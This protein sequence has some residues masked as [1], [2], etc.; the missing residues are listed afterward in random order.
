MFTKT[1]LHTNHTNPSLFQKEQGSSFIQPKLNV[2]KSGDK[3]EV[4]ADKAADQIVAKSNEHTNSFLA[5]S[6]TI[7]KQE[8]EQEIQQKPV[9]DP[10]TP[11]VQL[12]IDNFLQ[13]Q[14]EEE[15]QQ[16][17]EE[18][19]VQTQKDENL[20]ESKDTLQTKKTEVTPIQKI[21][22]E[23]EVQ[24]K[25]DEEIQEK[26][27]EGIVQKQSSSAGDDGSNIESQLSDS[28]GGGSPLDSDTKGEMESG[29]GADF[30]GVRVHND[31]NAVQMNQ[32]LG[33]QAFTN[34]NDIYFN[35]GKY[36]TSSDSGKHLL[37][38]E[39]THTVQQGASPNSVQ[40]KE[41]KT[42]KNESG[43][44]ISALDISQRFA[45]NDEW[46]TYLDGL[47]SKGERIFEVDVK[48][49][50]RYKGTIKVTKQ[51]STDT[52]KKA[53]YELYKKGLN[54][55]LDISGWNFMDPLVNAGVTPILVLNNFGDKQT[56]T[57]FLSV[58]MKG[59]PLLTDAL[60][61]I[62]G[63]NANLQKMN[64]HGVSTL[65]VSTDGLQN[66]FEQGKLNFQINALST[67]IAGY[68][69][70]GG[71]IGIVNDGF[72]LNFVGKVDVS[73]IASGEL[74]I[75]RK[76]DGKLDGSVE[77][78]ANIANVNAKLKVEYIKGDVTIQGT[79]RIQSE[80]FSGELTLL[81][82]DA[83]KSK[84]MMHAGLGV[85]TLE[86]DKKKAKAPDPSKKA[87][88]T[89]KN[90]VLVGW[91]TVEATIT[92]WLQ[93]KASVGIDHKGQVTIVGS[94]TVPNEVRLME[95]KGK[96]QDLFDVEIKAGYGIPLV[97]QVFLFAGVG[98]FV[99]AGFGPIVLK[100]VG[101]TGTYST[102]PAVLQ[103]F[104]ITGTLNINAF[105]LLGLKV[106]AGV[107]VTLL[108]H[109]IKA[110]VSATAAAGIQAYA[111]ATP[112]F[113]YKEKKNPKGG[114]VG[115]TRLK[116]SFEAAAELFL[117]LGGS[118]F[119]ELDSPWWSPAPDGR[120]D[121]PLGAVQ[122]PLDQMG[123][124]ADVDWLVG[125]EKPPELK[126]KPVKFDPGKFT[127]DLMAD[128]PKKKQGESKA[129]PKGKF[130]NKTGGGNK[131][132]DPKLNKGGAKGNPN[133]KKQDPKKLSDDKKYLQGLNELSK[134]EK[135]NPKP[136]I[137]VVE[138]K[139]KQ[140]KGKYGLETVTIKKKKDGEVTI[141][142]KHKKQNNGKRLLK[143]KLMSNAERM[144]LLTAAMAD[145]RKREEKIVDKKGT[146]EEAKAKD[147][148][149]AWTKK[150]PIIESAKV[151]DGKTTW[152]YEINTGDK[153]NVEK[154]KG[155]GG[156]ELGKSGVIT[157]TED[158]KDKADKQHRL[159]VSVKK[160]KMVVFMASEPDSLIDILKKAKTAKN[161][162]DVDTAIKAVEKLN[163][164]IKD[165]EA[166][167][168]EGKKETKSINSDIDKGLKA[169]KKIVKQFL[170]ND[171][172]ELPLS[173]VTYKM[174]NGKPK[175][176]IADPLT[177][178]PGNTK[179]SKPKDDPAGWDL[180]DEFKSGEF[181]V[182]ESGKGQ[183]LITTRKDKTKYV[184]LEDDSIQELEEGKYTSVVRPAG[185]VRFHVLN[186]QT[187]HGPGLFWNLLTASTGDNKRY[188]DGW[189]DK[190]NKKLNDPNYGVLYVNMQVSYK[191]ED[192][193]KL[194]IKGKKDSAALKK[195]YGK[196]FKS[197]P[198]KIVVKAGKLKKDKTGKNYV[199]DTDKTE[200][201]IFDGSVP[202]DFKEDIDF[203]LDPTLQIHVIARRA[204]IKS[205][206][207]GVPDAIPRAIKKNPS[208]KTVDALVA[209]L[210]TIV[211]KDETLFEYVTKLHSIL[212]D[213]SKLRVTLFKSDEDIEAT[214]TELKKHID[215]M[216]STVTTQE[217]RR[218][219]VKQIIEKIDSH[220]KP[221]TGKD[222]ASSDEIVKGTEL[223]KSD[224]SNYRKMK[225][226]VGVPL[227]TRV[228]EA[229]DRYKKENNIVE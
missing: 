119:Y 163:K 85:Q 175:E 191:T 210:K 25:E 78:E 29:F 167:L 107:G 132:K 196:L 225:K 68:I 174:S 209:S 84:Q 198:D 21:A 152:D 108:G 197:L 145:L 10:I 67:T 223:G 229:W 22:A 189:E 179:G 204:Q 148:L 168:K 50:K 123:I 222:K 227:Y 176:V 206:A 75:K 100:N 142:V 23:E 125:S 192:D 88:K 73:G 4:E 186:E 28:K 127:A 92:P 6:P 216:A 17:T 202:F 208:I 141:Y 53:K 61:F 102:D 66:K 185:W 110:G 180:V 201:T 44:P 36:D 165:H 46:A 156:K 5:P 32:E 79:G 217:Q 104:S 138:A 158:F 31:N 136:S 106:E 115:E 3:Y 40:K 49:G 72:T 83:A 63:L 35:E 48:I 95:Q 42:T 166:T 2:G 105:A 16:S 96:R 60:G 147:M 124:G 134:L 94:I 15:V 24:T 207:I 7:Q 18:E 71:G 211:S 34:G 116:G 26:E 140:V 109:D 182:R 177:R 151:V 62:K 12:K 41:D 215:A 113:E 214:K 111:E 27:E 181:L 14:T 19:A 150:H 30:S 184:T 195:E 117:Q 82:T 220:M 51:R 98:M 190:I 213:G 155:K 157:A 164:E 160:G 97:G 37:A 169:I 89:P 13:Q 135:A 224:L 187:M 81:V 9:V 101:F 193:L 8:N 120:T 65:N 149:A 56:T 137:S 80:K 55:Y 172:K 130:D 57:G 153:K 74:N 129:K 219:R 183:L 162:D 20:Q 199:K 144:K 99:N 226:N 86:G 59:A 205:V 11:G 126:F 122:Y 1:S 221:L 212:K 178:V 33:S 39:L 38:H 93:G 76:Q 103:N 154:G 52:G 64:M 200:F 218:A 139:M 114:K 58:K 91:G 188:Y 228:L 161:A 69:Q 87:K 131:Q 159:F 77:I 143:I 203:T 121:H 173:K 112:T 128:P 43:K 194:K 146:T 54:R 47:Y 45:L 133:A 90:Q 118:L 170:G 171:D 70:A